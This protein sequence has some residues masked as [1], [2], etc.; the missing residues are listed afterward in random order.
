MSNDGI[1][2]YYSDAAYTGT[3]IDGTAGVGKTAITNSRNAY[4]ATDFGTNLV[5]GRTVGVG[6]RVRYIGKEVDRGGKLLTVRHPQNTSLS[7]MNMSAILTDFS[8][9][10]PVPVTRQWSTVTYRPVSQNQITY[11]TSAAPSFQALSLAAI[12]DGAVTGAS[13][14]WEAVSYYEFTGDVGNKTPT[15]SDP[16]AMGV[17]RNLLP[18]SSKGGE[19]FF[20]KIVHGITETLNGHLA[21]KALTW[22]KNKAW[23][24]AKGVVTG[25]IQTLLEGIAPTLLLGL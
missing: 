20:K 11:W 22:V 19:S 7:G 12:V 3:T 5:Q 16:Q 1:F 21:T 23:S 14:E 17:V 9:V 8:E 6:L 18:E 2:G 10:E 24:Y 25:G 15:H 13:F 4:A